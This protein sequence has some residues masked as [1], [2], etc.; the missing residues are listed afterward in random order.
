MPKQNYC[1]G[2]DFFGTPKPL[3]IATA[4]VSATT[5]AAASFSSEKI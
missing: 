3:Q 5:I 1:L 4:L 2:I